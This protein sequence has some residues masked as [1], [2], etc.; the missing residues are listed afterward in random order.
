[1]MRTT[2]FWGFRVVVCF[3]LGF[4]SYSL[5]QLVMMTTTTQFWG[6]R[7]VFCFELIRVLLIL[8]GSAIDDD[9]NPV[10]GF[11]GRILF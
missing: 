1:M 9:N 2:Q 8:P 3:E 11:Q 7:V 10:L 4:H 6:F 5:D